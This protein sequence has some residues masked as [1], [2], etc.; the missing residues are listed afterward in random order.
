MIL[1]I[2]LKP[3]WIQST[4]HIFPFP[5]LKSYVTS[6]LVWIDSQLDMNHSFFQFPMDKETQRLY[7]FYMAKGLYK[8]NMLVQGASLASGKTHE[9]I[10]KILVGLEVVVQIKDDLSS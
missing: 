1:Q 6:L 5:Q 8:F 7:M 4:L 9:R 3:W 2:L 10:R